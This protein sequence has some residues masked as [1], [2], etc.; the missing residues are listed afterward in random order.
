MMKT[1]RL[2]IILAGLIL[3][4]SCKDGFIDDIT[5]VAPGEDV[6]AP[7]ITIDYPFEGAVIQVLEPI[8]PVEIKLKAADDIELQSV[9]VELDGDNIASFN[10]FKDYRQAIQTFTY[11]TLENGNHTLTVIAED[12]TG[13]TTSKSVNFIKKEPYEAKY[14]GELIYLPFDGDY[15][16]LLSLGSVTPAGNPTFVDGK[17]G[18]SIKLDAANS[19]YLTYPS[20][21]FAGV[22]SFSMAFWVKPTFVPN[23]ANDGIRGILGLVNFSNTTGFWGNIDYFVEN[24]SNPANSKLVV[25]VT[26]DDSESWFNDGTLAT[27]SGFFG[28]WS[29]HVITFDGDTRQFKYYINGSLYYSKAAGWTDA[30]TFKNPGPLV[31]GAVHF[32]TNPSSTSGSGS[33]G[34]ASYLT[35]EFDE[36]RIFDRAISA[37]VVEEIYDDEN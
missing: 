34:W 20:T 7:T 31:F 9:E 10:S 16:E 4:W 35:G 28:N 11:A 3:V 27:V 14:E 13:K 2:V 5:A 37:G 23:D 24:G 12:K 1:N 33:Q 8:A 29:H 18:K 26:N 25:H 22:S 17:K 36:I 19:A 30:L 15:L 21:V 32:M 6:T